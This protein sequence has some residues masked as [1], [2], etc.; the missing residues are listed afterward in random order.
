M[1]LLWA[2]VGFRGANFDQAP[3]GGVPPEGASRSS[4]EGPGAAY[5]A[6]MNSL[7]TKR[8]ASPMTSAL[9]NE[10]W[11]GLSV[12]ISGDTIVVGAPK[13]D[14]GANRGQGSAYVFVRTGPG[15]D[16]WRMM[17]RLTASD[18]AEFDEFGTSVA[19]SGDTVVVGSP[20][21][22]L[23]A[24]DHGA[25][26]VFQRNHGGADNWGEVERLTA[27]DGAHE[28]FFGRSVAIGGETVAVGASGHGGEEWSRGAAYVFARDEG[29]TDNWGETQKL[30]ASDGGFADEFGWSIA[31]SRESIVVGARGADVS[32]TPNQGA[33]Y[34]F[35][36][37]QDG[38]GSWGEVKKLA[39]A[40]GNYN[41]L[42]GWSIA[43]S[44][45]TVV[46][47]ARKL[48]PSRDTRPAS[49]YV[50]V[51]NPAN[52][53]WDGVKKLVS[54]DSDLVKQFGES[55]A[56]SE[57]TVVVGARSNNLNILATRS[58]TSAFIFA[59][60]ESGEN[61]W[62][63][64][65][66]LIPRDDAG[67]DWFGSSVAISGDTIVAGAPFLSLGPNASSACVYVRDQGG[68]D[69]WGEVKE[70]TAE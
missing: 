60:N 30:I 61:N 11:F 43:I 39:A 45:D 26:Y 69:N 35:A 59:R 63:L 52:G 42:F 29:G 17:K 23:D 46:V 24:D 13:D 56:I 9:P 18:G 14:I 57:D 58:Y 16:D 70:L 32:G 22:D 19:I 5:P 64:V 47:G 54:P 34:V 12:A 36:R 8:L 41:D 3:H 15:A 21:H 38:D 40:D 10:D 37:S 2:L 65:K 31:I 48:N 66:Q 67:Q 1:S 55:V 62:G 50:F 28:D 51:R 33:A 49:A 27:S 44:G 20:F 6:A 4:L 25:A 68:T 7:L 53:N